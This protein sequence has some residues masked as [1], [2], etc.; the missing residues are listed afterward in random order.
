MNIFPFV[1]GH[2][3]VPGY[4]AVAHVLAARAYHGTPGGIGPYL[5]GA[6]LVVAIAAYIIV[7]QHAHWTGCEAA[8]RPDRSHRGH[9]ITAITGPYPSRPASANEERR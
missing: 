3:G 4:G 8:A 9:P 7:R 5:L 6:V 1:T 2:H